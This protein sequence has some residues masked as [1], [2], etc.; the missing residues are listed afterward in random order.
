[1][2][3]FLSN[4]LTCFFCKRVI[5]SRVE[6]AQLPYANPNDVGDLARHGRAWVHRACWNEAALR[7]PWAESAIRLLISDPANISRDGVVCR[8]N[9]ESILLQDPWQAVALTLPLDRVAHFVTANEHG[10]AVSFNATIWS[11]DLVDGLIQVAGAHN[12]EPFEVFHQA[13][14]RWSPVLSQV[15]AVTP[16]PT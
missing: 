8:V 2:S 9:K 13:P 16:S 7:E 15:L 1:M 11:F 4:R 14:G 12:E 5:E 6:A 3:F 10:G